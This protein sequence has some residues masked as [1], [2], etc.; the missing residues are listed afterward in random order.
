M[1]FYVFTSHLTNCNVQTN[2]RS[3]KNTIL[4]ERTLKF[5]QSTKMKINYDS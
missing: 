1:I 5:A 2:N 4:A 3:K